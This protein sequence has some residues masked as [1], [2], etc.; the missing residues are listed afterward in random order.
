MPGTGDLRIRGSLDLAADESDDPL[1]GLVLGAHERERVLPAEV[2]PP[3]LGYPVGIR[4]LQRGFRG[5]DVAEPVEERRQSVGEPAQD[6]VREGDRPLEPRAAHELDRLVHRRVARNPVHESELVRTEPQRSSHGRVET[7]D[8]APAKLLDRV[9]ERPHPLHRAESQPLRECAVARVQPFRSRPERAVGVR[10]V[11][12]DPKEDVERRPPGRAYLSPRSHAAYSIRRPP[13]GCTSSGSNDP[14][15]P[16]RARQTVTSLPS[17]C[18]RAPIWG[19]S[20]R[21]RSTSSRAR[22]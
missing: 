14:S 11:L 3:H 13:F 4:V 19:E 15:S 12:E 8:R 6:R 16:T 2:A 10:I 9:V 21:T 18:V 5:R 20:A 7:A 17:S 1:R 22:P